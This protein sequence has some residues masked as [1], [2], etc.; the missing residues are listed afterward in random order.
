MSQLGRNVENK[1]KK[2]SHSMAEGWPTLRR[3][4]VSSHTKHML[5]ITHAVCVAHTCWTHNEALMIEIERDTPSCRC[6]GMKKGFLLVNLKYWL[7]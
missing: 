4:G 3:G 7:Q 6:L 1:N 5:F 2:K